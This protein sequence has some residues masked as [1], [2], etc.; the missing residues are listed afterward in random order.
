M[1]DVADLGRIRIVGASPAVLTVAITGEM[2][3]EDDAD[4]VNDLR[5]ALEATPPPTLVLDLTG[6][7]FI[8][9]S[10]LAAL[11]NIRNQGWHVVLVPSVIVRRVV[12]T[13][14]LDEIF[15]LRDPD[16]PA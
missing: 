3:V 7:T 8:D 10:G 11:I 12:E 16:D 2:D 14:G 9:S 15:E 4:V 1:C 13:S 5:A 6:V